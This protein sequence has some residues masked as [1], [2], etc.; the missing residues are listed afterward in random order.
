MV[1]LRGVI[2]ELIGMGFLNLKHGILI[3]NT[4]HI[5]SHYKIHHAM[6]DRV[7]EFMGKGVSDSNQKQ[8]RLCTTHLHQNLKIRSSSFKT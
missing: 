4:F 6:G 3:F 1:M 8:S 2:K 5:T 7:K